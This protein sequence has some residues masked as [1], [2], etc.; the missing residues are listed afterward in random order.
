VRYAP[1]R[2]GY[3]LPSGLRGFAPDGKSPQVAREMGTGQRYLCG[4]EAYLPPVQALPT[5]A[6]LT[7]HPRDLPAGSLPGPID[8]AK[9]FRS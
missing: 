1:E 4:S 2:E 5:V 7:V 9:F 3:P 6:L 8:R